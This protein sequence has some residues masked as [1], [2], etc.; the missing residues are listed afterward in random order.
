VV[1]QSALDQMD[2]ILILLKSI[3][4]LLERIL[5]RPFAISRVQVLFRE[6]VMHH[7]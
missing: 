1:A 7:L 6:V 5:F 2:S 4:R 3:R